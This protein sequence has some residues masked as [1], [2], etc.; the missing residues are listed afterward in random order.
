M[1][2]ITNG[3]PMSFDIEDKGKMARDKIAAKTI[4]S[5]TR[6]VVSGHLSKRR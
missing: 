4:S 6:P 1:L 3:Y 2:N 5:N